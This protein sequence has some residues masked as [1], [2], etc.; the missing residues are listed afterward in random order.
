VLRWRPVIAGGI[1]HVVTEDDVYG[2]LHHSE[3]H[4]SLRQ[5]VGDKEHDETEYEAPD[6][7][8]PER[9]LN[10]K[11]GRQ[12]SGDKAMIVEEE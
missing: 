12:V 6:I 11:Y 7:F 2:G 3:R 4:D 5:C 9:F 8:M 10:H 1:P